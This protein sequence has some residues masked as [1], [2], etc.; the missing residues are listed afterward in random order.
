V[1]QAF[2]Y[3]FWVQSGRL[4]TNFLNALDAVVLKQFQLVQNNGKT[5]VNSA[6]NGVSFSYTTSNSLEPLDVIQMAVNVIRETKDLEQEEIEGAILGSSSQLTY[7]LF[8]T[9]V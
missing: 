7:G 5:L 4:K 6:V 8:S 9:L 2:A 1:N 3:A